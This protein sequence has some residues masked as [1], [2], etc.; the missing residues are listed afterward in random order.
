[1]ST[2]E[3]LAVRLLLAVGNR[4]VERRL[5]SELAAQGIAIAA[6]CL[7]GP[8]LLERALGGGIDVV[9]AS[10][11]LHRLTRQSLAALLEGGLAV[12]VLAR[13]ADEAAGLA[14]LV[15]VLPA[16][17]SG[18]VVARALRQA[19]DAA[20]RAH[21]LQLPPEATAPRAGG[22]PESGA[23]TIGVPHPAAVPSSAAAAA[24]APDRPGD[25]PGEERG[26]GHRA[27]HRGVDPDIHAATRRAR[28]CLV[29]LTSGK[30]A[31]GK[32]TMAIAL[33]AL[34]GARGH[35]LV[36]L[37]ADLRGGN[38]APYLDLDPRRG[39][40]GLSQPDAP[41][42]DE[43]QEGPGFRVLAGLERPELSA[44]MGEE[45][46][47]RVVAQLRERFDLIVADLGAP[48][49]RQLLAQ[50]EWVLVVTGPDLVS[51]WNAR[52]AV[53]AITDGARG[54]VTSVIVNRREGRDHHE[55][56]E[57]ERALGIPVGAV[58]REERAAAR[59]TVADQR[60]L[61]A[62]APRIASD[63][64]RLSAGIASRLGAYPVGASAST[65]RGGD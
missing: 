41:L 50:A 57:I 7:D 1:M 17:A 25:D 43:L 49:D 21:S 63:L 12:V 47:P 58:V 31:P 38:V 46:L 9:L 53:P 10:S 26:Q 52:I 2:A 19:L 37:D 39:L 61:L 20:S 8:T 55:A 51:I 33:A 45:V 3:Q 13:D 30:G 23:V 6:R 36:L 28:G 14:E 34:L 24:G 16:A 62:R 32:T 22:Q 4:D 29:A 18:Q 42:A 60:P 5:T 27:P 44:G 48:P 35:D 54:T 11:D 56:A 15:G 65:T 64:R 59:R 40:V